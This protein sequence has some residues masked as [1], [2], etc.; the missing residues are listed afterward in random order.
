MK[1]ETLFNYM[2]RCRP[3]VPWIVA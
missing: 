1:K 3:L 2:R